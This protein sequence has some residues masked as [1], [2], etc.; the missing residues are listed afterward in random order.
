MRDW[1]PAPREAGEKGCFCRDRV[2]VRHQSVP[3]HR[4]LAEPES[5]RKGRGSPRGAAS[6]SPI[7]GGKLLAL[8]GSPCM[9]PLRVTQAF[10]QRG[11]LRAAELPDGGRGLQG[12]EPPPARRTLRGLRC[13]TVTLLTPT[14]SKRVTSPST[15][16]AQGGA[17]ESMSQCVGRGRSRVRWRRA[18]RM[19]HPGNSSTPFLRTLARPVLGRGASG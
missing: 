8:R 16:N 1:R 4:G 10:S 17:V 3:S 19:G 12:Q 18:G 6:G 11:C 7:P 5:Y 14:G 15:L 2:R 13:H 9:R